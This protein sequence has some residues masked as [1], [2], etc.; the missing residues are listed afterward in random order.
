MVL[1]GGLGAQVAGP[2]REDI[3]RRPGYF[4]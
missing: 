1:A 4:T 2:P 3:A